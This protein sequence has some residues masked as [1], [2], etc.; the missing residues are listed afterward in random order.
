VVARTNQHL[1]AQK[2]A[3]LG[4]GRHDD[5]I[6]V[7]VD[8]SRPAHVVC[9]CLTQ[10]RGAMRI[11]VAGRHRRRLCANPVTKPPPDVGG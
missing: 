1:A 2:E 3:L 7:A 5:L 8:R 6:G 4:P 9:N 11:A 10:D